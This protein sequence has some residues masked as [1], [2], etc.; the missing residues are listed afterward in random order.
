MSG[1]EFPSN[2]L[3]YTRPLHCFLQKLKFELPC[4]L[5]ISL[6]SNSLAKLALLIH[7]FLQMKS[8]HDSLDGRISSLENLKHA[9]APQHV[10][11]TE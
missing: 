10:E 11:A 2:Y 9:E 4:L 3:L 8:L 1:L 5:G 6:I 7:L